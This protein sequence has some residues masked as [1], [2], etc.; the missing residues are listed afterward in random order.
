VSAPEQPIG[1][2]AVRKLYSKLYVFF[3]YWL[4]RPTQ[5]LVGVKRFLLI[6]VKQERFSANV[7]ASSDRAAMPL[8]GS[9][10]IRPAA[11]SGLGVAPVSLDCSCWWRWRVA[12]LR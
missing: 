11:S 8:G 2:D 9:P 4:V 6:P 10:A 1:G 5:N 12:C 7:W 3:L